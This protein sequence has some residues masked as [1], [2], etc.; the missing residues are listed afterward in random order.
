MSPSLK[1]RSNQILDFK[2]GSNKSYMIFMN[3]RIWFVSFLYV[4]VPKT[5]KTIFFYNGSYRKA[6]YLFLLILLK[7][8]SAVTKELLRVAITMLMLYP[9]AAGTLM[10][11]F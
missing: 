10:K 9:K 2:L 1:G 6:C 8:T 11:K 3:D 5:I 7:A 4:I